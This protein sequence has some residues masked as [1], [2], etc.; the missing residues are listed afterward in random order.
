MPKFFTRRKYYC[1]GKKVFAEKV[2]QE[3]INNESMDHKM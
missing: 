3:E 1:N 2:T